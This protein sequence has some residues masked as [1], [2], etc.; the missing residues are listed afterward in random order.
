[1]ITVQEAARRLSAAGVPSAMHDA[2]ALLRHADQSGVDVEELLAQRARRVPLQHLVG[3]AGFRYLDL[4][5]GSG[6]FVPR[7]ESELLVE[8]VLA[9]IADSD[10]P[11]VVDL[12]AGSGAIGLSIA[13]EHPTV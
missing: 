9:A 13:H 12:C 8:T 1:M 10:Q 4:K 3:S 5:V 7:P 2:R 11:H 6:V